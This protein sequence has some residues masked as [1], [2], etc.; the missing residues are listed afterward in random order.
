MTDDIILGLFEL[1]NFYVAIITLRDT[2]KVSTV[3]VFENAEQLDPFLIEL[4]NNPLL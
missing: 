1:G 4:E 3:K 2:G